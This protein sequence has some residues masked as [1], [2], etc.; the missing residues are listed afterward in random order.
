[1]TNNNIFFTIAINQQATHFASSE[2]NFTIL[3]TEQKLGTK[4]NCR[5]YY[6]FDPNLDLDLQW[7]SWNHNQNA[8]KSWEYLLIKIKDNLYSGFINKSKTQ[9]NV[10]YC[11]L[12]P[13]EP[14]EI[15]PIKTGY[16]K[17]EMTA[18]EWTSHSIKG[19]QFGDKKIMKGLKREEAE[20]LDYQQLQTQPM[21]VAS[22]VSFKTNNGVVITQKDKM[23]R[24]SIDNLKAQLINGHWTPRQF[25][26]DWDYWDKDKN[27]ANL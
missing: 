20:Q 17:L 15:D 18:E 7:L 16:W 23:F 27:Q 5:W 1:M 14:S 26:Q 21:K 24:P 10:Y 13:F 2:H 12:E 19:Y 11:K 22:Q 4:G 3:S 8:T 6:D 25:E 9:A